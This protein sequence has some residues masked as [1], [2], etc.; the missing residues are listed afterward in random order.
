MWRLVKGI[1]AEG[2]CGCLCAWTDCVSMDLWVCVLLPLVFLTGKTLT[3]SEKGHI[4]YFIIVLGILKSKKYWNL[5]LPPFILFVW[6]I[7]PLSMPVVIFQYLFSHL[8]ISAHQSEWERADLRAGRCGLT[9]L[10][11]SGSL[12]FRQR[13]SNVYLLWPHSKSH[14]GLAPHPPSQLFL[15][16]CAFITL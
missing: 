5:Q 8:P 3:S 15:H 10:P 2:G 14:N 9:Q 4:E 13:L 1:L 6:E 11:Y 7:I 12:I 16:E